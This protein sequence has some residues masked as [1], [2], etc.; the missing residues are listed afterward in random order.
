MIDGV[1]I[2]CTGTDHNEWYKVDEL[3][4]AIKVSKRTGEVLDHTSIAQYR[5]L[6][7]KIIPSNEHP[8]VYHPYV[9]GSLHK[10][11]NSGNNNANGFY[12]YELVNTI[13]ELQEKYHIDPNNAQ[14][15]NVEFGVNIHLQVKAKKFLKSV[16]CMPDK[17]FEKLNIEKVEL[18][19]ILV[20]TEYDVK[21]YDE[22]KQANIDDEHLIRLEVKVKKMRFLQ[23]YNIKT[24]AD[25]KAPDKV[26]SIAQ[27][28]IK[29]VGVVV[30]YDG[31]IDETKLSISERLKLANFKNP[32][33]WSELP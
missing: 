19:H 16:I 27:V 18:G 23:R 15:R 20:R 5:G 9:S 22:G 26:H 8:G 10:Y 14:L 2:E 24:L 6:L 33:Y 11:A 30:F 12:F 1:K 29:L 32:N 21:I 7:F 4:F 3:D 31:S 17:A 28:L 25:L 13:G